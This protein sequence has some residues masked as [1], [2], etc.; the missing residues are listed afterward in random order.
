MTGIDLVV[1]DLDGTLWH[2]D[3][4]LH[5]RTT[6]GV[7]ELGRSGIPLL[8][9]TG[10]RVGSTRGPLA[11]F[12]LTP[13]AVVLNGAVALD[14][15][16]GERFHRF[17]FSAEDAAEVLGCFSAR[18]LDPCVYVDHGDTEVFVSPSPSTH[19]GH[20][21]QLGAAARVGDLLDVTAT[22][23][24]LAFAIMGLADEVLGPVAELVSS[25][26]VPYLDR[27]I[28]FGGG[29]LTVAP[30]GLSKWVGVVA[31]C[32][33]AGLDTGAVLA[34]GDGPNDIELLSNAKVA[35]APEGAHPSLSAIAHH[36]VPS[37]RDG[38]WAS[39]LELL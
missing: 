27:S 24:V 6:W 1:T 32:D 33:L 38:G 18:G 20:L 7:R 5:P 39:L 23:P 22:L 12:G 37:A 25:V 10:R 9:A 4:R 13:P 35:V 19:P 17:A 15:G 14:L 29:A 16:T 2:T 26:A 28:D 21:R 36:V 31:Y 3:D 30:R 8:V 34:I 11:R